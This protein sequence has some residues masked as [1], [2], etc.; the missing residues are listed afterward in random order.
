MLQEENNIIKQVEVAT[1]LIKCNGRTVAA[2]TGRGFESRR[3]D[4]HILLMKQSTFAA[5]FDILI[6][7]DGALT[8]PLKSGAVASGREMILPMRDV[9]ELEVPKC[10]INA[11]V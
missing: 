5:R 7:A 9:A 3:P 4:F 6:C 8:V 2:A 11:C 10:A 1:N